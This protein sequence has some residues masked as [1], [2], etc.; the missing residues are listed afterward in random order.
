MGFGRAQRDRRGAARPRPVNAEGSRGG[1]GPTLAEPESA[2]SLLVEGIERAGLVPGEQ[3][4]FAIDVAATHVYDGS[5]YQLA[6]EPAE[7]DAASLV[8]RLAQIVGRYPIASIEDGLAEDDWAG[9]AILTRR[10]AAGVQIIGD[11]LFTTNAGRLARGIQD[12]VANAVLVKM[13]QIGT[14]TETIEVIEQAQAAGY[15]PVVS[16][17]SGE[18]SDDFIADLAVGTS[19]GQIKI[20][21]L[22]QSERLAKYNQLLRIEEQLG[23]AAVFAGSAAIA[24]L[25]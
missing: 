9:W 21:S 3:V 10:L 25:R 15:A 22:A 6:P 17:R 7:L 16:A 5:H 11:D 23:S 20:G 14:L 19:A 4:A 2:L 12:G 1:F 24:S 13:N 18:M 8:E